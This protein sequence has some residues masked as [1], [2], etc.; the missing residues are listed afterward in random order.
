[1]SRSRNRLL[2]GA[3]NSNAV[4]LINFRL[5]S[6]AMMFCPGCKK[7]KIDDQFIKYNR[8]GNKI[9]TRMC[10][11][12][13]DRRVGYYE[14]KKLFRHDGHD[15]TINMDLRPGRRLTLKRNNNMETPS[16]NKRRTWTRPLLPPVEE[17]MISE[18]R[19]MEDSSLPCPTAML[20]ALDPS[21]V[22]ES[23]SSSPHQ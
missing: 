18:P 16:S 3:H 12:C 4:R 22:T 20:L 23:M 9:P 6:F 19:S 10:R 11:F 1:M 21:L 8:D 2:R 13:R 17:S 7:T 5:F 14:K 15:W